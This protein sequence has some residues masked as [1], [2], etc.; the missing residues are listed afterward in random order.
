MTAATWPDP[1]ADD[2]AVKPAD[3]IGHRVSLLNKT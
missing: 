3:S 2:N 1:P